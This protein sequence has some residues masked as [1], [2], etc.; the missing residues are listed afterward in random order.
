MAKQQHQSGF[1]YPQPQQ[2]V[3]AFGLLMFFVFKGKGQL[4][5]EHEKAI[6]EGTSLLFAAK[7]YK[8]G[9][10]TDWQKQVMSEAASDRMNDCVTRLT[11]LTMR[12]VLR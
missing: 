6:Q 5:P 1:Y 2:D 4:P 10:Y 12:I 7:L 3:W 11:L 9:K 8:T